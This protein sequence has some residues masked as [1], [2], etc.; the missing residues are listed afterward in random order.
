MKLLNEHEHFVVENFSICF[1]VTS[2]SVLGGLKS[3]E[4]RPLAERL[5]ELCPKAF[6]KS[7][8]VIGN[9]IGAIRETVLNYSKICDVVVVSGGTGISR[10]DVSIEAVEPL[11]NKK[12]LGFGELFR[13]LSYK[14]IGVRAYIS[15]ASAYVVNNSLVF[16]VP[17][18]PDAVKLAL[19]IICEVA[20]HAIYEA[21]RT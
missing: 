10:R 20:P 12:I 3:D 19:E 21:R 14:Q 2:E 1:I 4:I 15:R 7:Y 13:A 5:H 16:V 11:S 9:D 6:V 8:L 18:N 17:G